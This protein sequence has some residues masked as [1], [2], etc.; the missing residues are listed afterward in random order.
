MRP[1]FKL[2]PRV[3]AM[4]STL[5]LMSAS[6]ASLSPS[7]VGLVYSVALTMSLAASYRCGQLQLLGQ[8]LKEQ[9]RQLGTVWKSKQFGVSIRGG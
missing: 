1:Q 8:A 9:A 6:S 3:C 4:Y 7:L 2:V 5:S